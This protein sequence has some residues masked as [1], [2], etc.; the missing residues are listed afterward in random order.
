MGVDPADPPSKKPMQFDQLQDF[1]VTS[2]NRPGQF[3]QQKQDFLSV[4][5]MAAGDFP[6]HEFMAENLPFLKVTDETRVAATQMV[7]PNGCVGKNHDG[8]GTDGF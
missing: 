8:S 5:E 2:R 3:A 4:L 1:F 6:R 7:H